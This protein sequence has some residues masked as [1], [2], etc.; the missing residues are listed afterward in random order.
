MRRVQE[1]LEYLE[2]AIAV[3]DWE[4][5]SYINRPFEIRKDE[6]TQLCREHLCLSIIWIQVQLTGDY[7]TCSCALIY[8]VL[9]FSTFALKSSTRT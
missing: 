1:D 8:F 4:S 3:S 7:Q 5:I 2:D 6:G 9:I